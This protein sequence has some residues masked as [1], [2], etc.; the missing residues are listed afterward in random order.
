MLNERKARGSKMFLKFLDQRIVREKGFLILFKRSPWLITLE[1]AVMG[2][3]HVKGERQAKRAGAKQ[4]GGINAGGKKW[5]PLGKTNSCPLSG[6]ANLM[7]YPYF[8]HSDSQRESRC[9]LGSS[10]IR[11]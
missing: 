8:T 11:H 4:P 6:R 10:P 5:R 7:K 9:P 3:R 2:R 1:G